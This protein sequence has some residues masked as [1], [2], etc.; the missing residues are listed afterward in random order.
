VAYKYVRIRVVGDQRKESISIV[1][2]LSWMVEGN[3]CECNKQPK[4]RVQIVKDEFTRLE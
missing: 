4:P 2:D 3:S 1:R